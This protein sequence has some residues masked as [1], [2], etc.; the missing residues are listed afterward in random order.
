MRR[1]LANIRPGLRGDPA[2]VVTDAESSVSDHSR[3]SFESGMAL[4][5]HPIDSHLWLF[6]DLLPTRPDQI[7][8]AL[9]QQADS[10]SPTAF[11]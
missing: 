8:V 1:P 3:C 6:K 9:S 11:P 2:S 4:S 10:Q 7:L 5:R